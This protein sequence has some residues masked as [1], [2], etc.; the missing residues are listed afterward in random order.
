MGLTLRSILEAIL[1]VAERPIPEAE[2]A[3]VTERPRQEIADELAALAADLEGRQAGF[4]LQ[5][6]GGGWRLFSHP[7]ARPYLEQFAAGPTAARLSQA[8]LETLS[9]VAYRQPVTRAQVSEIRGVDSE[10]SLQ[11]LERLGLVA[12]IGIA[13]GPG[14]PLLYGTTDLFVEKLGLDALDEL[15]P[16]ADHV[17]PPQILDALERPFRT[18]QVAEDES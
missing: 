3:E 5:R 7:E 4:Q 18:S 15:P 14:S 13:P 9:V 10:R 2:L 6:V 1:F 12:E 17:P 8:A 11:T 16:L